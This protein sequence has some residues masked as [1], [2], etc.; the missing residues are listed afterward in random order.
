[1][2]YVFKYIYQ[3]TARKLK[4]KQIGQDLNMYIILIGEIF[5]D[6]EYMFIKGSLTLL[7]QSLFSFGKQRNDKDKTNIS[8]SLTEQKQLKTINLTNLTLA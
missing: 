1:M 7:L 4:S 8:Q 2:E 3:K 6:F 5:I